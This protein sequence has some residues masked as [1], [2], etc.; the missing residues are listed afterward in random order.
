MATGYNVRVGDA[1]R[2]AVAA[3]LRE[4]YAD[5]RLTIEELNERL[6]QTFAAKTKADLNTVTRDLPQATR[7]TAGM[8][9]GGTAWQGAAWQGPMA[10]RPG[11][12][13][14]HDWDGGQQPRGPGPFA[15]M[16]GLVWLFVI[17]GS[18]ILFGGFG[19]GGRPLAIVLF[20]AALALV[21]RL[22]GLGRRRGGPG[23][24]GPR[25]PR[26]RRRW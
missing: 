19:G 25:G 7:P 1:D 13:H 3:Q 12:D 10:T 18:V 16:M 17:F 2:E 22:I 24:G 9:Y 8:P 21:R 6:D 26:G 23:P 4:H 14:G 15:P 5:G 11:Q 20:L